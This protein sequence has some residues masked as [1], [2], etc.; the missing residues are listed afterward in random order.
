MILRTIAILT[1]CLCLESLAPAR[2]G[3]GPSTSAAE[4][5]V[6]GHVQQLQRAY[7]PPSEQGFGSAVFHSTLRPGDSL[8]TAALEYYRRFVGSKWQRFG[9]QAWMGSWREV[10]S[11][12]EDA[13]HDIVAELRG[14]A[15]PDTR[16]SVPMI[17]EVVE[18]AAAAR[19]ALSA[20]FDAP[21]VTELRVFNLGDGGAMS[22]LLVAGRRA[23]TGEAVMLVFLLD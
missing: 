11:R 16:N 18:D 19:A 10:Y 14:I 4:Q 23:A 15:D 22:G 7:G 1:T 8:A 13:P 9:E 17:L 5:G 12:G 3:T 6:P 21:Q 2:A 20:A